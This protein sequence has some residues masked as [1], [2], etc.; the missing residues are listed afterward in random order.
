MTFAALFVT[1]KRDKRKVTL[2]FSDEKYK[3][4]SLIRK[5]GRIYIPPLFISSQI[6]EPLL[7]SLY[8]LLS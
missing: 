5:S 2:F 4:S 7:C 6:K 3:K 1:K 8:L